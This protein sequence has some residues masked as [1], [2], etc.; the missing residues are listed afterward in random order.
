MGDLI[1]QGHEIHREDILAA[2]GK[3]WLKIASLE[4]TDTGNSFISLFP[5]LQRT[6]LLHASIEGKR[7]GR[8]QDWEF[9][10]TSLLGNWYTILT[11]KGG[12]T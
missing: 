7:E 5:Y 3:L 10:L 12:I 1:Y 9:L 2:I 4:D 8:V 11:L 6:V